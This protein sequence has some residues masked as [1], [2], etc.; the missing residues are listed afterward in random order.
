MATDEHG[1][2]RARSFN[3]ARLTD[4][5][6]DEL[7]GLCKGVL[8][9]GS[10]SQL[11]AEFLQ[12]WIEGNREVA[13]LFPA[14]ILYSRISRMLEDGVLDL[15]EEK[16]LL[17]TLVQVTGGPT[18][19]PTID[20]M[21]SALPLCDPPPEIAFDHRI[22]YFT[23]KFVYGTRRQVETEATARGGRTKGKPTRDTD[24]LVI[25]SIGSSDW[26]HSTHGRKIERAIE[27]R[28]ESLPIRIVAEEHW[29]SY[30]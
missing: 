24:Y 30:L 1:Q 13:N 21:S 6:I 15:Q 7:I 16:D 19:D 17:E 12:R 9:D 27:L 29:V 18:L 23:G 11:D 8:I 25:G 2:P 3:A 5:K 28:D 20:T 26:I 22:F 10:V 14:N 4:R